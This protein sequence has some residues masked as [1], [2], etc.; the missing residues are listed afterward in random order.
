MWHILRHFV[1]KHKRKSPTN[2]VWNFFVPRIR[3]TTL[4]TLIR[5]R[6][7]LLKY[8][9]F[10]NF[11]STT[12][13]TIILVRTLCWILYDDLVE[14]YFRTTLLIIIEVLHFWVLFQYKLVANYCSKTLLVIIVVWHRCCLLYE[15]FF[16]IIVLLPCWWLL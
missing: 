1:W 6:C 15:D 11:C 9:L 7:C 2:S 13:L 12:L 5:L 16:L 10:A 14:D 4:L 8:N 3:K